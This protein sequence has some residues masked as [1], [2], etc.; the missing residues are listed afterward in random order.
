MKDKED[1]YVP[2]IEE[3]HVGFEFEFAG[4]DNYWNKTKYSKCCVS[5]EGL[6]TLSWVKSLFKGNDSV[7]F[8]DHIRV[9]HLDRE[10]IES[11]GFTCYQ[12]SN[13]SQWR[14]HKDNLGL[15]YNPKSKELGT[16]T[17]DPSKSDFMMKHTIDNKMISVLRIKNKSE[18]K[19]ILK[20]LGILW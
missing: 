14:F 16:F 20:Q 9:K 4:L 11:L 18:L 1:Y 3:L 6:Y 12:N 5:K 15:M 19:R 2:E 13:D 17:L 8:K 10:D 7:D